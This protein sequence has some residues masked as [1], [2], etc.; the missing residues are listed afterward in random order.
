M[1][2]P[3]PLLLF[4]EELP[5]V[6]SAEHL[7]HTLHKDCTMDQ[8]ARQKRAQFI[9]RTSEL[10]SVSGFA[11]PEQIIKAAQVY[12]S[13]AYGFMLYDFS[14]QASQSYFKSW[15]TF[16]K[17]AWNVP[18]NTYTYLVENTLAANFTSLKKQIMSRFTK[19]FQ[20]LL[21]S[22]SKEVRHLARIL[23]RDARTTLFRNIQ[24]IE[25]VSLFESMGLL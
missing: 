13:D 4:G 18:L 24:Y 16:V 25:E 17:L 7:G 15:N 19:F 14:S 3:D 12:A 9:D 6:N 21:T 11:H 23:S 5:L 20:N 8:D 10:R 1:I 2:L 22:S